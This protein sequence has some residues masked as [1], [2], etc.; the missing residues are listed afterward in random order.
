VTGS[1]NA[2]F[3]RSG[4]A[5]VLLLAIALRAAAYVEA[6][7]PIEGAGLAAEQAEMAR[8]IVDRGKWF[9]V[10][11]SALVLLQ[12]RQIREEQLIDPSHVDFSRAD[13]HPS[14]RLE[15]QQMPGVAL[16]LSGLWWITGHKTYA[17]IQ[18][19]QILLDASMVMLIFWIGR[20]LT[21]STFVGIFAALLYA[22]WIGAIVVAKRPVPD[23]WAVFFTV[24]CLGAFVWARQRPQNIWRLVPFGVLAGLGI[25]FRPF[26]ALLPI[27]LG[28]VGTPRPGWRTR[29]AWI[30]LPTSVALLVLSPWTIRNYYEFHRFIPTRTGLGQAVFEGSGGAATDE[31]AAA[32]VRRDNPKARYGTPKYDDALLRRAGRL[33]LDDPWLYLRRVLRRARFLLPCLLVVL[34]WRRWKKEALMVAAVAV[35]TIVPYLFIGDD[36]RFYLPAA[37]AYLILGAMASSVIVS[38]LL[39]WSGSLWN[40]EAVA[41]RLRGSSR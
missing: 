10:N 13:R 19:L 1:T 7:R 34:V 16:V 31:A 3:R 29:L 39:R 36:T 2:T 30:A 25:Y 14:Y 8:N 35:A 26:M 24:A 38:H 32:A 15:V 4:L 17:S 23:T 40:R 21:S 41:A 28:L 33:I 22:V 11:D 27:A 9:V 37:F 6:P 18:W 12:Q 5:L 20:R